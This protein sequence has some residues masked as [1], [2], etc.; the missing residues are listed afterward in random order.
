M[1]LIMISPAQMLQCCLSTDSEDDPDFYHHSSEQG[2]SLALGLKWVINEFLCKFNL[3]ASKDSRAH[4]FKGVMSE[5][6][7]TSG[8]AI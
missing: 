7:I 2:L 3:V 4:M 6:K 5:K 1:A 8:K